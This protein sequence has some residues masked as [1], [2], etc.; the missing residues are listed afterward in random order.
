MP[1]VQALRKE[2]NQDR[3]NSILND[4]NLDASTKYKRM[5]DLATQFSNDSRVQTIQN[6]LRGFQQYQ[7]DLNKMLQKG[8]KDGGID[9]EQYDF[10]LRKARKE[11]ARQGK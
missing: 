1:K 10:L 9:R 8:A 7:A 6:N 5:K 11:Y 4:K 2:Y 3:V